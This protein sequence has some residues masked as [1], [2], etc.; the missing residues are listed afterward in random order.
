MKNLNKGIVFVYHKGNKIKVLELDNAVK[1]GEALLKK[2][3]THTATLDPCT[4]IEYLF[5][6]CTDE[7]KIKT[8]KD[9]KKI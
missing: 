3:Y 1:N 6:K 7:E 2:G 4:F 8:V 5:N 9:L